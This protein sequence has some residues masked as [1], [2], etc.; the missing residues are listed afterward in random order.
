MKSDSGIIF[1]EYGKGDTIGESDALLN[2]MRDCYAVPFELC[3][4]YII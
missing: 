4:L 2:Q 3:I 1:I